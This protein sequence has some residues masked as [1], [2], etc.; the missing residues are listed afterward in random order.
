MKNKKPETIADLKINWTFD[1]TINDINTNRKLFNKLNP[2]LVNVKLKENTIDLIY[3]DI[4]FSST[5]W[6][7]EVSSFL[8]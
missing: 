8:H 2:K 1:L 6:K 3:N 4:R 7:N 5:P